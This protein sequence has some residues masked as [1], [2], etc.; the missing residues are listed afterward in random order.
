M[1][2]SRYSAWPLI[3]IG[4]VGNFTIYL[5]Y[6]KR[7]VSHNL[8]NLAMVQIFRVIRNEPFLTARTILLFRCY[9][10]AAFSENEDS[11]RRSIAPTFV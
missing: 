8:D 6:P 9:R 1:S 4:Y 3:Y 10:T 11:E 2:Q 7:A 5:N